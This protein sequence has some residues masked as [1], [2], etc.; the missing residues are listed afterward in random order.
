MM[1]I[2]GNHHDLYEKFAKNSEDHMIKYFGNDEFITYEYDGGYDLIDMKWIENSRSMID[3]VF[4]LKMSD[5]E[6]IELMRQS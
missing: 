3:C 2:G 6:M 1:W 5:K 4:A